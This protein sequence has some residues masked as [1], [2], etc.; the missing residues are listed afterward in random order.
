MAK[1]TTNVGLVKAIFV[2]A[3]APA[4]TNVIWRDTVNN[5]HK[6]YN[7]S[8]SQWEP[9]VE[10]VLIDN[11]TIK[12]DINGKLYVDQT[13]LA[14]YVLSN[15][16]V[17]LLKMA[18]VASGTIF[19]RKSAGSGPPEVQTL[20]QLRTDLNIPNAPNLSLYAL[21]TYT[22]NG[23][24]L[25]GNITLSA[26]DI[27][28]PAGSGDSTGTNTG[29]E[30]SA[31][32]LAKLGITVLSGENTGDQDATE[33]SI[34]DAGDIFLSGTVEAALTEVKLIADQNKLDLQKTPHIEEITLPSASTVAGRIAAVGADYPAGWTLTEG[35][36]DKDLLITHNLNR[37]VA[38]V[39]V[40]AVTG[41]EEQ[42]L[43]NTAA[44]NGIKTPTTNSLL[45]QSLATI[46]KQIKI[47]IIFK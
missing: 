43:L 7:L 46:T 19:Y 28:S 1:K 38:Y 36:S 23:K 5:I 8:T 26:T 22:I 11:D 18:D 37:R 42:Q 47:Y 3:V 32:I 14:G 2:G 13:A 41:T 12:K 45:I 21:K 20:A 33:I 25:N 29:D 34:I 15:G 40:W 24:A 39:T 30:T 27:G 6:A 9:L 4:N 17:T 16:S 35:G 31:T 44:N 10:Y